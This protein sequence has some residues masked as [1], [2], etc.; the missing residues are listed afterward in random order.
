M[1]ANP[2]QLT[3][4][5]AIAER[6]A[7]MQRVES[8]AEKDW[9]GWRLAAL[10][11]VKLYCFER[12]ANFIAEDLVAASKAYGLEQAADDKAWGPVFKAA[13]RAGYIAFVG[14]ANSPNRHLSPTRQWRSLIYRR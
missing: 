10:R 12:R 14:W 6:D 13:A 5:H 7:A 4:E 11:Y 9:P 8:K 1:G 3:I 2:S